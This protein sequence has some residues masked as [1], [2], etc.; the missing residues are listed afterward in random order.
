MQYLD[1]EQNSDEWFS[2]R[3]G[4]LTGSSVSKI[5]AKPSEYL[6]FKYGDDAYKIGNLK[7]KKILKKEYTCPLEANNAMVK[8]QSKISSKFSQ[9]AIDLAIK[10]ALE[11]ITGKLSENDSITSR[12]MDR[13]HIQECE[14]IR[15]YENQ[16]FVEVTNG[17]FFDCGRTGFSPDGLVY[18]CGLIE[19]KSVISSVQYKNIK[20]TGIDPAYKWQI[21]DNLMQSKRDWIDSISYCAD[22]PEGKKLHIVRVKKEDCLDDFYLINERKNKFFILIEEIKINIMKG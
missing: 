17:G 12:H 2:A 6:V 13:G 8:M 19:V 3:L 18:D 16:E 10:I 9:P 21:L 22:Y 7:T 11:K 4:K 20:R 1:I 14:V 5:M 15:I